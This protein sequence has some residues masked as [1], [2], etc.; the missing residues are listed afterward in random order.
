MTLFF[1]LKNKVLPYYQNKEQIDPLVNRIQQ[2]VMTMAL[3][4]RLFLET[5]TETKKFEDCTTNEIKK[6]EENATKRLS[7]TLSQYY[8]QH[9]KEFECIGRSCTQ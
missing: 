9:Q 3:T 1:C 5:E 4:Y 2:G 6:F 7:N 8:T